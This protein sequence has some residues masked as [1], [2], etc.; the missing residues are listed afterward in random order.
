MTEDTKGDRAAAAAEL[1]GNDIANIDD[2]SAPRPPKSLAEAMAESEA[3]VD[4]SLIHPLLT[5]AEVLAARKKAQDRHLAGQKKA[6]MAA[7]EAQELEALQGP[8]GLVTGNATLDEMVDY[9]VMLPEFAPHIAINGRPYHHGHT[10][11]V[12][13]HVAQGLSEQCQRANH[14]ELEINGRGIVDKLRQEKKPMVSAATL[15]VVH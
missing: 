13:R 3:E 8:A 14:H 4:P 12:P 6:A 11:H 10:Y 1:L 2:G 5:P 9:T 15:A 7:I